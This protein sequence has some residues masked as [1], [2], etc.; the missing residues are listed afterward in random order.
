MWQLKWDRPI[1]FEI[2]T[3][4]KFRIARCLRILFCVR[5]RKISNIFMTS[6]CKLYF[7]ILVDWHA[8]NVNTFLFIYFFVLHFFSATNLSNQTI[9]IIKTDDTINYFIKISCFNYFFIC[10]IRV[11]FELNCFPTQT[12]ANSTICQHLNTFNFTLSKNCRCFF[13]NRRKKF[14][15]NKEKTST[16]ER[17]LRQMKKKGKM[18]EKEK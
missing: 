6:I 14:S 10:Q 16:N 18:K 13:F 1:S 4:A 15:V 3:R 8:W 5:Q 12:W 7:I 9:S 11:Y 17:K 2:N